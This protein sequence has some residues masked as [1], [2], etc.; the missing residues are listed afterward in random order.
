MK[1]FGLFIDGGWTQP[2]QGATFQSFNPYTGKAWAELREASEAEVGCAAEAAAQ[3]QPAWAATSGVDRAQILNRAA[4][5]LA[6]NADNMSVVES[7]DNGKI[8]RETRSQMLYAARL[9]RF[10]AGYADKLYGTTIP[11]DQPSILDYTIREPL[12]VVGLITAWNSPITLLCNKLPAALAAGNTVVIKPSEHASVSTLELCKLLDEAGMPAGVVNVVTGAGATGAAIVAHDKI[13]K[14]SFTGSADVGRKIA[15]AAGSL[16]KPMALE[17]GG[18]S[19]NI[20]FDDANVEAA[21]VGALA[22]IFGATGQT[23]VA[24]SRLLVQ[25]GLYHEIVDRLSKRARIIRLGDPL[26]PASEMGTVANQTQFDRIMAAIALAKQ[27]GAQLVAGGGRAQ[28]AGL[29]NGL[30]VEPTIFAEARNDMELARSEIFGPV[31]A[32]IPFETEAEAVA[33]ANDTEFGLASGIWTQDI[34]RAMRLVP[35]M[36]SGVVWVN[37][38]RMVTAQAPFGGVKQS[39]YGRERGEQGIYEFTTTKNVMIDYSGEI[40]D[41]FAIKI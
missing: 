39:G 8:I 37:T 11:L 31:L 7:T 23:C 38:Y 2:G 21:T 34:S 13:A 28:G 5:I 30:F 15:A 32:V 20:I 17:L 9:F 10:F 12:G 27:D 3:A 22:G 26:D 36:K 1:K 4:D 35:Q 33:I 24:G 25:K 41:P 19:P 14:V 29:G 40:R 16:L 6:A 18:K